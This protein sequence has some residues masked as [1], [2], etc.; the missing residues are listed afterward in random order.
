[1]LAS[2]TSGKLEFWV[3]AFGTRADIREY[4]IATAIVFA[5][6]AMPLLSACSDN[7]GSKNSAPAEPPGVIAIVAESRPFSQAAEFIGQT[8]ALQ[9]VDLRARVTGYLIDKGFADG[10]PVKVGSLLFRIEPAEFQATLISAEAGLERANAEL[11]NAKQQLERT[12]VLASQETASKAQLDDKIA[13]EA[14]A[15][16]NVSAATADVEKAKLNL[17]YTEIKSPIEGRIGKSQVDVGNLVGPDSGILATV[18]TQDPMRVVFSV[19]EKTF[20]SVQ[21]RRA[22]SGNVDAKIKFAND[23][24][25]AQTGK[26]VFVDNQVDTGTG[27]IRVYLEFSNPDGLLLP[28]LFVTVILSSNQ[29]EERILVPQSVV[30]LDQAGPFVLVVDGESKVERRSVTTGDRRGA[31]IVILD[32]L[33]AGETVIAEGIQKVRP[34][35]T[36]TT[37][38]LTPTGE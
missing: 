32:G 31:D 2:R 21:A 9:K 26:L 36:V 4:L 8:E 29:E 17:G 16:A 7:R 5:V 1:M 25:Y 30:Q 37:T 20:L 33:V 14:A 6:A 22:N 23:E 11:L 13:L 3:M 12:T 27:T 18:V 35:M 19:S 24:Q 10:T 34:G 38:Y 15:Q 28:G